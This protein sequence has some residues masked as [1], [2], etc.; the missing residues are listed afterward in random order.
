[1]KL[2]LFHLWRA[3]LIWIL[4]RLETETSFCKTIFPAVL[5]ELDCWGI[6]DIWY[7]YPHFLKSYLCPY[8][9]FFSIVFAIIVSKQPHL[10]LIVFLHLPVI[11]YIH[12]SFLVVSCAVS[13][14]PKCP[15]LS[16]LCLHSNPP[17]LSGCPFTPHLS[18]LFLFRLHLRVSI[19]FCAISQNSQ[20][21]CEWSTLANN[22]K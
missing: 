15:S 2:I 16:P 3:N 22:D 14:C 5:K 7:K 21:K 8:I 20:W 9:I 11:L 18:I 12:F 1:M 10:S 13:C 17:L 4:A 19:I 6:F